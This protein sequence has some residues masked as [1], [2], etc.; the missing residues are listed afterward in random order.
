VCQQS[1]DGNSHFSVFPERLVSDFQDAEEAYARAVA[2]ADYVREQWIA[3]KRPVVLVKPSGLSRV[4]P[5]L[6]AVQESETLANR[7]RGELGLT[8]KSAKAAI[9]RG[10]GR[11]AGAASALDR[12]APSVVKLRGV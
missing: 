1:H 9:R 8:P 4:H 2:D 10:P 5:L 11:P 12:I 7:L 6:Q 3:A